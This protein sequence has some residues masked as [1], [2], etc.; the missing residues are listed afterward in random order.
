MSTLPQL[1]LFSWEKVDRSPEILRLGR[2]LDA[3]PDGKL[4]SALEAARKGK[5]NDYP[6]RAVWRSVVAGVALGHATTASLIRELRRNAELREVCGFDL[7]ARD[8]VVPRDYVYSRFFALL[9]KHAALVEEMFQSLISSLGDILPD[10]GANLAAD[11]KALVARGARPADANLGTKRY[12]SVGRDGAVTEQ[13]QHWFGW[14]LHLLVDADTE[15]PLAFEVTGASIGDSPRLMPLVESYKENQPTLH[16]RGKTLS[17]DKAYDGVRNKALLYERHGIAPLI[18]PCDT[19]AVRAG[20]GMQPLD[21]NQ[22]DTIFLG[23]TGH[24]LCRIAPFELDKE[25]IYAPMQFLGY[26]KN[27]DTLKFRCPA[28]AHGI[29]C[30]NREACR[31]RPTVRDGRYGRVVRVPRNRDPRTLMPIHYHSRNFAKA[32]KKRTSVERVFSRL[33]NVHGF[34]NAIVKSRQR[35]QTRVAIALISMLATARSWIEH[36]RPEQMRRIL[37]AA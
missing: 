29:E 37:C 7:L 9:E 31:C 15:L 4:L 24:V 21:P 17:A 14:K 10:F 26:E 36:Q 25:K 6:L 33:D 3:L 28:T 13:I 30:K 35:M 16:A 8:K 11:S 19:T 12:E 20:D 32:Y 1:S 27:R 34:E 2:L 18:P 5:R 22:S 23:A